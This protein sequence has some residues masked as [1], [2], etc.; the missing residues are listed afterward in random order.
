MINRRNA[1]VFTLAAAAMLAAS[2]ARADESPLAIVTLF[3]KVSAGKDGKYSG[4]SAYYQDKIRAKYFSKGL[5]ALADALDKKAKTE[6]GVGLDFDPI[7]D[8]QD[9]SVKDLK[10]EP[11]GESDGEA[12]VKASFAV[13]SE[14]GGVGPRKVIRFV[15]LREAKAWKL[16]NMTA[17]QGDDGWDLRK[18][19]KADLAEKAN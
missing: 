16:D 7:T 5:R 9:P 10:F 3:Y 12:A 2:S 13:E 11:D 15:F 1:L 14:T 8:S 4:N 17:G 6:N 18:L 19:L